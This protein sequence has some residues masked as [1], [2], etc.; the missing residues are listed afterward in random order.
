MPDRRLRRRDFLKVSGASAATL[1]AS[2][3]VGLEQPDGTRIKQGGF[4][5]LV[6][7]RS[8]LGHGFLARGELNYLSSLLFRQSFTETFHEAIFSEVHS[9][10]Y[11]TKQWSSYSLDL[12][13]QR[14]DN[15]QSI[16]KGDSVII[17]KLPEL[18]FSSR[19]RR[20]DHFHRVH[21]GIEPHRSRAGA[22]RKRAC[23]LHPVHRIRSPPGM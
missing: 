18:E 10:G 22:A 12:V 1:G 14:I 21:V 19:D 9:V 11:I 8:D 6:N 16:E 20:E 5:V 13:F 23:A 17:R 15:F 3:A 2:G 7:G 4:S